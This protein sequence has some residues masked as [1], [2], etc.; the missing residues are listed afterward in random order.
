[1]KKLLGIL[2]LCLLLSVNAYADSKFDKDLKKI[3]LKLK[4]PHKEI[5]EDL[6]KIKAHGGLREK[7]INKK[8]LKKQE[9]KKI[10]DLGSF[11]FKNFYKKF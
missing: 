10:K 6:K 9:L 8:S 5:L 3:L 2:V 4:I 11:F 1:M 7:T